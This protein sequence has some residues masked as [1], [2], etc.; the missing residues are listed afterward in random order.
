MPEEEN[1]DNIEEQNT[2]EY[3]TT[4]DI[5]E[6]TPADDKT[7]DQTPSG[8]S[9]KG[10]AGYKAGE[11]PSAISPDFDQGVSWSI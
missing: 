7:D 2:T 8:T 5:S 4:G 9:K 10:Q 11:D 6:E 1:I 3:T